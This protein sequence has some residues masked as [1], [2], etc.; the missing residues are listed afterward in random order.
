MK[1]TFTICE[2]ITV[3]FNNLSFCWEHETGNLWKCTILNVA[4]EEIYIAHNNPFDT[5]PEF[6]PVTRQSF[7]KEIIEE[8]TEEWIP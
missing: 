6:D 1:N 7:E 3:T 2:P 8:Y 5:S 4:N